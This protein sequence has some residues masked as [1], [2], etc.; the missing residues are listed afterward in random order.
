M[1]NDKM[2]RDPGSDKILSL[3]VP[4]YNMEKYLPA[5]LDSVTDELI[6]D[7]LEVIVVND[8]STDRSPDII[9]QYEQKRP[10][11]IKVIDKP[12]GHYG[13]CVNA[14]LAVATGKY[15]KIL[16]ADD[17]FD[18]QALAAFLHKLETCDTDLVIT[19]RVD[20]LFDGDQ[21]VDE[22][23]H[24]F[25]TVFKDHVYQAAEF[26]I[27]THAYESEFGMNGMAYKTRLLRDMGFRLPEGIN[28]TDTL[29]CFLPY[30][31]VK[32]FVVYD[33][34]LYH[35]RIGRE[36]QSV[37][38][39]SQKKNLMQ[40]VEMVEAMFNRM[41]AET[42]GKHV[43]K[44]Q[45]YFVDGAVNFCLHSLKMQSRIKPSDYPQFDSLIRH[46]RKYGVRH[47]LFKKWYLKL[48][49]KT[50]S[51]RALDWALRLHSLANGK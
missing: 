47:P 13:S 26:S 31:Q 27:R 12:N 20:E 7:S 30:S 44:N 37:G 18:T 35:Y 34:Y 33:L 25:N 49:R 45:A 39:D 28:Y 10:D 8:G 3:V 4:T 51:A 32:D 50:E 40:I 38:S 14:G 36:G 46:I 22:Q 17:W 11:L 16:D 43:R 24:S 41:D 42:V 19:L 21:K 9:R 48:W 23:K 2:A 6:G 1:V 5:C 29:Y 15:F